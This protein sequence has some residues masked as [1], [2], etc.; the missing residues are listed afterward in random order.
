LIDERGGTVLKGTMT[1]PI[2]MSSGPP[3]SR[4]DRILDPASCPAPLQRARIVRNSLSP[5][6]ATPAPSEILR[7]ARPEELCRFIVATVPQPPYTNHNPTTTYALRNRLP[8]GALGISLC[9]NGG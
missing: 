8:P 3:P 6:A 7:R 2:Q 1:S 9:W 4:V 5:L